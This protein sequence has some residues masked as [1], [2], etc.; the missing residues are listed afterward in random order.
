[1]LSVAKSQQQISDT[2]SVTLSIVKF[3]HE[4]WQQQPCIPLRAT[5]AF[6]F[7][8]YNMGVEP[9]G[10]TVREVDSNN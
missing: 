8:T 4:F 6:L 7:D 9:S 1:M 5:T 3:R 2:C 10:S